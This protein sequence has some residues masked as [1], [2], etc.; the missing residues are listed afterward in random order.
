[1]TEYK[2]LGELSPCITKALYGKPMPSSKITPFKHQNER[3][4]WCR[5]RKNTT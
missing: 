1:M 3:S 5:C 4:E 2:C